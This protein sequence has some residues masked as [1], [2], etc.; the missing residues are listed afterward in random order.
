MTRTAIAK[1][2]PTMKATIEFS[3]V[4]LKEFNAFVNATGCRQKAAVQAALLLLMDQDAEERELAL[5][6]LMHSGYLKQAR[7][8]ATIEF[9]RELLHRFQDFTRNTGIKQRSA[10]QA[11]LYFWMGRSPDTRDELMRRVADIEQS[12]VNRSKGGA[13]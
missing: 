1:S 11:A 3:A 2:R 12:P 6:N 9:D 7:R 4:L 8:K 13:A 5:R 10:V